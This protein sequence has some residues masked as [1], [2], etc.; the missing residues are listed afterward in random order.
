M[1]FRR[2]NYLPAALGGRSGFPLW[3]TWEGEATWLDKESHTFRGVLSFPFQAACTPPPPSRPGSVTYGSH[4]PR[5][6]LWELIGTGI[7]L[8]NHWWEPNY[9]PPPRP[10][11]SLKP[12]AGHFPDCGQGA[13]HLSNH[14]GLANI[15]HGL[16]RFHP[17]PY[18]PCPPNDWDTSPVVEGH[19][20]A[21]DP[22]PLSNW[23][24]QLPSGGLTGM[25]N[26]GGTR[27]SGRN[28]PMGLNTHT[29][30]G[31]GN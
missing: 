19:R 5:P 9:F 2:T 13:L 7:W 16:P 17:T 11:Q 25:P 23:T 6:E 27:G 15:H 20:A 1:F 10:R 18:F 8:S 12:S 21:S 30:L 24:P 14:Y 31:E 4:W 3:Q 28:P 22:L 29:A 26:A